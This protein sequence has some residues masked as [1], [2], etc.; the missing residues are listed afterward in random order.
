MENR[1]E[2]DYTTMEEVILL[3]EQADTQK[4]SDKLKAVAIK[5]NGG[6]KKLKQYVADVV[7]LQDKSKISTT[8]SEWFKTNRKPVRIPLKYVVRM[9]RHWGLDIFEVLEK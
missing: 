4:M 1:K 3:H 5:H 9:C 7:G 6:E 8:I 2:V